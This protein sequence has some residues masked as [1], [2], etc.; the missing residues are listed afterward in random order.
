MIIANPLFDRAF[1]Q[2][3]RD[4]EVAKAIIE[5][6]LETEVVQVGV[7][8]SKCDMS[9]NADDTRLRFLHENHSVLVRDKDEATQEILV[10]MRKG[11]WAEDIMRF[12]EYAVAG[13][14]PNMDETH[15]IPT[16]NIYF[17]GFKLNQ[18]DRALAGSWDGSSPECIEFGPYDMYEKAQLALIEYGS[19]L[20][21][22]DKFALE[23]RKKFVYN[24]P[25]ETNHQAM[26]GEAR[27]EGIDQGMRQ[28]QV[29][30]GETM[31][32]AGFSVEDIAKATNIDADDIRYL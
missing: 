3:V 32:A 19:K 7:P 12:R 26:I 22:R 29:Q 17:L 21:E 23:E 31:K 6:L 8:H 10:K 14:L 15:A 28:R 4:Q 2:L 24:H 18:V 9:L 25:F 11:S 13:Y 20:L 1:K 30:I 5:T 27:K 16:I